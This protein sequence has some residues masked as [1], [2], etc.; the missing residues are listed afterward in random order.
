VQNRTFNSKIASFF[1]CTC[2]LYLN[3]NPATADVRTEYLINLLENGSSYR[4]KIQAAQSLGRLQ[5]KEAIPSLIKALKDESSPVVIAAA[6]ALGEIGDASALPALKAAN[7]KKHTTAVR[8]QL[9]ASIR[10]L[11][12]AISEKTGTDVAE[13]EPANVRFIVKVDAMG[14]SSATTTPNITE[15]MR[16]T[17]ISVLSQ[18]SNVEIQPDSMTE[19]QIRKIRKKKKVITF[20]LSGALI[21]LR[22]ENQFMI[23]KVALNVLS[24]PDYN[25]VMMPSGEARVPIDDSVVSAAKQQG[26]SPETVNSLEKKAMAIAEKLVLEKLIGNLVGKILVAVP[27]VL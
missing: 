3:S 14:N 11:Q 2:I 20:I 4:V 7:Q 27:D 15:L 12:A 1:L 13:S 24:N 18:N 21:E 5:C 16:N 26:A 9:S 8:I 22:R 23:A 25:L 19:S 10:L 6:A 17:V